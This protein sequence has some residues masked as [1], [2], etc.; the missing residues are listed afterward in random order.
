MTF[1]RQ[2]FAVVLFTF[3]S[4]T[5]GGAIIVDVELDAQQDIIEWTLNVTPDPDLIGSG[6]GTMAVEL[7]FEYTAEIDFSSFVIDPQFLQPVDPSLIADPGQNPYTGSITPGLSLHDEAVSEF[8]IASPVDAFFIS[9]G[10]TAF[11]SEGPKEVLSFTTPSCYGGN[12][13]FRGVVAQEG[14]VSQAV[15]DSRGIIIDFFVGDA[16]KMPGVTGGDLLAVTNNFGATGP[17]DGSLLGDMDLD[18]QVTGGDLLAVTNFFGS[19]GPICEGDFADLTHS[20]VPEPATLTLVLLAAC[21]FLLR[22]PMAKKA[23]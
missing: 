22:I 20:P 12:L 7:A 10:S 4:A 11:T 9:L 13:A 6:D 15:E 17:S 14:G 3:A 19:R 1:R 18:G 8:G 16:D 2:M 5:A 21:L 23:C